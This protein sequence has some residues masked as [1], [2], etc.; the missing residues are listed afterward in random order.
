M[1]TTK[2]IKSR[3]KEFVRGKAFPLAF[4]LVFIGL[5]MELILG[6]VINSSGRMSWVRAVAAGEM[7][8]TIN[9]I[10]SMLLGLLGV[11]FIMDVVLGVF[12][13]GASWA[14]VQWRVTNTPPKNQ[15]KASMRFWRKDVV[16]DSVVLIAARLFFVALW[17]LLLFI[18]GVIKQYGY[19]QATFL[20]AE[21]VAAGRSIK[22]AGT[23]LKDSTRLMRGHKMQLFALQLS[24][25]GWFILDLITMKMSALYSRPYYTAALS[26]FY[27][28]LRVQHQ[29]DNDKQ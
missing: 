1:S 14:F 18:P 4:N 7:T 3:G 13:I 20:Y 8:A 16:K 19:S 25:I 24:F 17:S 27:L 5:I 22:S 11:Q 21:D 15:Y 29:V 23:Y 28:A 10:R 6:M 26:E 2:Q 12:M 9:Q